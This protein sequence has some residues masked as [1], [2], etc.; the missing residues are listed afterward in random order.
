MLCPCVLVFAVD[1][2]SKEALQLQPAA[3]LP[4]ALGP[5]VHVA[6]C[7]AQ[8]REVCLMARDAMPCH[9]MPC[10]SL[11]YIISHG[12]QHG[13]HLHAYYVDRGD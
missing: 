7:V 5:P 4:E 1:G 8:V 3:W 13:L 10:S 11:V 12:P 6:G 9:A 2:W